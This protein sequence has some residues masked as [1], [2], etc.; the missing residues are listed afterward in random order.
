[1]TVE[2]ATT[3]I[4]RRARCADPDSSY[5]DLFFSEDPINVARAKAICA[6]CTVR[7]LCLSTALRRQEAYGVWGGE[8]V[9]DGEIK[10]DIPRRGRPRKV[11]RIIAKV[12]EVTGEPIVA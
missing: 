9:V 11:S 12:D 8:L 1:M 10:V 4:A 3:M 7:Q 5:T 6:M 2:S